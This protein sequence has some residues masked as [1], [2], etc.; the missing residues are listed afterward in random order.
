[1]KTIYAPVKQMKLHTIRTWKK[2]LSC[3]CPYYEC[4][5]GRSKDEYSSISC[6]HCRI[7]AIGNNNSVWIKYLYTEE[8]LSAAIWYKPWTWNKTVW[9]RINIMSEKKL[10]E[11]I[12]YNAGKNLDVAELERMFKLK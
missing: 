1:M 6:P 7:L 11:K 8:L 9:V 10:N 5:Q 2:C 12:E 4:V 3:K